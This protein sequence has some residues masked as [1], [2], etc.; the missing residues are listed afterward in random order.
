MSANTP[1]P[2]RVTLRAEEREAL[3]DAASGY[4]V[5]SGYYSLSLSAMDGRELLDDHGMA[6]EFE[7]ILAAR[8]QALREEIAGEIDTKYREAQAG[9]HRGT[10]LEGYLDGLDAAESIALGGAR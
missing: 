5:G 1:T 8:E 2:E 10:Y 7:R 6:A 9:P 3:A 4:V